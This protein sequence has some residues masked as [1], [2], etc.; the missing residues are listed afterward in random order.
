M[1]QSKWR[2]YSPKYWGLHLLF[3]IIRL[4]VYLPFRWQ[5]KIGQCLGRI[6]YPLST[7]RR[8]IAMVNLRIAFPEKQPA[9]LEEIC[10]KS[11]ESTVI[12][13][14]DTMIAW[15]M[16]KKRFDKIRFDVHG[17]EHFLTANEDR[18]RGVLLLGA[19]FTCMEIVG[20]YISEKYAPLNIVYQ[21]HKNPLF[22]RVMV[23]SREKYAARCI[24]RKNVLSIVRNLKAQAPVWYA[25]DQD[26]GNERTIFVDFF[27]EKC[28]TLVATSWLAEKTNAIVVPCHFAR[29]DDLS[30]YD[31]FA[32]PPL[33][34][35]P[36]GDVYK[37][38]RRYNTIV[39]NAVRQYPDQYLW[40]HRRY[41][42]RPEGEEYLY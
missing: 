22:E 34:D 24:E 38:A 23:E 8:H 31:F 35:F 37:D 42:T 9:E 2:W 20:R 32:L 25:P 17:M 10:K 40:Q 5:M 13:A 7:R 4:F 1:A 3:G 26:F 28:T 18:N 11:F 27:T 6:A 41:K 14:F 39:E 12:S 36:S 33:D 29:K 19:H 15:F 16:P 30:G 21:K